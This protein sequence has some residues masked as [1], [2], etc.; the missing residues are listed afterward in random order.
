MQRGAQ[1]LGPV[2]D[3]VVVVAGCSRF[4]ARLP[5]RRE[6]KVLLRP[7]ERGVRKS[8][9][10]TEPPRPNQNNSTVSGIKCVEVSLKSKCA[11]QLKTT[12]IFQ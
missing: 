6:S 12:T 3:K 8:K 7:P 2:Q 1:T 10:I 11:F 4:Y 9:G 5:G